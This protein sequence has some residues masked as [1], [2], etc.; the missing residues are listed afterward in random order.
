[1]PDYG[2]ETSLSSLSTHTSK[3]YLE[4]PPAHQEHTVQSLVLARSLTYTPARTHAHK[5][6]ATATATAAGA[7]AQLADS[8]A[9]VSRKL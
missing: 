4:L 7:A 5:H 3:E 8:S 9:G 1:M 2:H 6:T